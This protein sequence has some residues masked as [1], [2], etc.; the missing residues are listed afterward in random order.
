M[1]GENTKGG[2]KHRKRNHSYEGTCPTQERQV[3][4]VGRMAEQQARKG[5]YNH[6][7]KTG[8]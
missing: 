3:V 2:Q 1:Q 5:V 7:V 6:A 8:H 4:R